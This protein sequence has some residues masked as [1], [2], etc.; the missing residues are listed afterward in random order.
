MGLCPSGRRRDKV[1]GGV[2]SG[3]RGAPRKGESVRVSVTRKFSPEL[4]SALSEVTDNQSDFI[5]EWMWQNPMLQN[6]PLKPR[7]SYIEI[8]LRDD[9]LDLQDQINKKCKGVWHPTPR[10][11][12]AHVIGVSRDTDTAILDEM[13]VEYRLR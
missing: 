12:N 5:E 6:S 8:L 4:L 13:G 9:Q 1:V 2:M 3:K 11:P 7:K 10:E